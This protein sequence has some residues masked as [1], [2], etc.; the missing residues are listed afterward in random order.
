MAM[1]LPMLV[2]VLLV[3]LYLPSSKNSN[4]NTAKFS[5]SPEIIQEIAQF[6]TVAPVTCDDVTQIIPEWN[7][8]IGQIN[9]LVGT[10]FAQISTN[11]LDCN[12]LLDYLPVVSSYNE[13]VLTAGR[14]NPGNGT[15]EE[16]FYTAAFFFGAS[17]TIM[18]DEI[19]YQIGFKTTGYL[20]DLLGLQKVADYCGYGCYAELL[21]QLHWFVR[22]N[23][24]QVLPQF[25]AWVI[26]NLP[27][28]P[29][30]R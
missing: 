15:S 6:P 1:I 30:N 20:N 23:G 12:H 5:D 11:K 24:N 22:T 28:V 21:S 4:T 2:I 13:L 10:G 18:D 16:D 29:T 17:I 9:Q 25:E 19:A 27:N 14:Y 8:T 3:V 7:I 26:R